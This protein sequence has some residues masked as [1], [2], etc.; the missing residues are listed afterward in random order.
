M[1]AE[2]FGHHRFGMLVMYPSSLLPVVASLKSGAAAWSSLVPLAG[3]EEL[4]GFC[5]HHASI[6]IE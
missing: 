6:S 2:A 5:D 1:S 3:R 4:R